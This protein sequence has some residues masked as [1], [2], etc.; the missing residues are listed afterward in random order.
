M[1]KLIFLIILMSIFMVM[2]C[3]SGPQNHSN[4]PEWIHHPTRTVDNG[5]ILYVGEGEDRVIEKSRFKA[6]SMAIQDL[7]NECSLAPKGTRIEDKYDQ[8]VGEGYRSYAKVAVEISEC[9]QAKKAT[10]PQDIR[11]L[12]NVAMT[13]QLKRYQAI[14]DEP[15]PEEKPEEVAQVDTSKSEEFHITGEDHFFVVRQQVAYAK[16]VVILSPTTAYQPGSPETI[17]LTH[18]I[19]PAISGLGNYEANHPE[20]KTT[21]RT[22]ST[23]K[24]QKQMGRPRSLN[25]PPKPAPP[26]GSG[27]GRGSSPS[28]RQRG[29]KS[30]RIP[31]PD[32]DTSGGR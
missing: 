23:Y 15:S 2:G 25:P 1:Q 8:P 7:V 24:M 6:E 4:D 30:R 16:E 29:R 9:D 18:H 5:Y 14:V 13:E 3:S 31:P 19:Q 22:W 32:E 12:A 26:R 21:S 11:S 17:Q 28:Y 10:E 27:H 20:I